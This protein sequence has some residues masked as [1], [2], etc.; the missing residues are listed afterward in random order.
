MIKY[1]NTAQNILT[2]QIQ[3]ADFVHQY[4]RV[5]IIAND[6]SLATYYNNVSASYTYRL[7]SIEVTRL[8]KNDH[9]KFVDNKNLQT[10]IANSRKQN[11]DIAGFDEW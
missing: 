10:Y 5:Q 3:L 4:P 9:G 11:F 8:R 7:G 2:Q 1:I 6:I